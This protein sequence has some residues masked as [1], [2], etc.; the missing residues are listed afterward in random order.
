MSE[1]DCRRRLIGWREWISLPELGINRIKAKIDTGARTSS[2]DVQDCRIVEQELGVWAEFTVVHGSRKKPKFTRSSARVVEQRKITDSGGHVENRIV[3]KTPV[4]LG[5]IEKEIEITLAS[6]SG[7][8]FRMLLGRTSLSGE[9][10]ID[11]SQS[12]LL[13]K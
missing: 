7:M 5:K 10:L 9:Y 13:R 4:K 2:L 12:Y 1:K 6:R 8:K 11:L 3:I